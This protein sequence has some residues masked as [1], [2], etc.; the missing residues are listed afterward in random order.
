MIGK[1]SQLE[2][3]I[4]LSSSTDNNYSPTHK[5]EI[6]SPEAEAPPTI[7]QSPHFVN[8]WLIFSEIVSESDL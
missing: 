7:G 6:D 4:G 3:R 8:D 1:L 2:I 5:K